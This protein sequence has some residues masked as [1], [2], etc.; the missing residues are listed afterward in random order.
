MLFPL[1]PFWSGICSW[2]NEFP[3]FNMIKQNNPMTAVRAFIKQAVF[4]LRT[5]S[6]L[7]SSILV[8]CFQ[9]PISCSSS[10]VR[11]M[12]GVS[13]IGAVRTRY[14]RF[15]DDSLR[16]VCGRACLQNYSEEVHRVFW[17]PLA[18]PSRHLCQK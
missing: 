11:S 9:I 8:T 16:F 10:A 4:F 17:P 12:E 14:L 2:A 3:D 15:Q 6:I 1:L 18:H 13:V 7:L 5:L